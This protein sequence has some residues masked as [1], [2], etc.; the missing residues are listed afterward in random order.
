MNPIENLWHELKEFLRREVKLNT[1]EELISGIQQFRAERVTVEKCWKY[2]G[3][4]KIVVPKVIAL[5]VGPTGY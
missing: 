2:I 5:E 3:H 1:N 4:F